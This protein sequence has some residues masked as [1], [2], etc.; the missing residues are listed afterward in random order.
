LNGC[1]NRTADASKAVRVT[2]ESVAAT[3]R[4]RAALL[5]FTSAREQADRL[6]VRTVV[7]ASKIRIARS[8]R[9]ARLLTA[10]A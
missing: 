4:T 6:E 8:T 7:D 10:P 1:L 2:G 5:S 3:I 9:T